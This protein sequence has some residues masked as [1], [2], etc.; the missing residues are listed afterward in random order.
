MPIVRRDP[1]ARSRITNAG[2]DRPPKVNDISFGP[3]P[4]IDRVAR[5][6]GSGDRGPGVR[7]VEDRGGRFDRGVAPCHRSRARMAVPRSPSS[8]RRHA[9]PHPTS[10][11]HSGAHRPRRSPT[12]RESRR[13]ERLFPRSW[14]EVTPRDPWRDQSDGPGR[15][16]SGTDWQD[17]HPGTLMADARGRSGSELTESRHNRLPMTIPPRIGRRPAVTVPPCR[18]CRGASRRPGQGARATTPRGPWRLPSLGP[19]RRP[20][21]PWC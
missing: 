10:R 9:R 1:S 6:D 21:R 20:G 11:R 14:G 13:I 5:L 4:C 15:G 17:L 8:R 19:S 7:G 2:C 12:L 3:L 18:S 16:Q